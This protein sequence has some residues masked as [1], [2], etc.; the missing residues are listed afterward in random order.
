MARAKCSTGL[1]VTRPI[2]NSPALFPHRLLKIPPVSAV[3]PGKRSFRRGDHLT[4]CVAYEGIA[5][6]GVRFDEL[7]QHSFQCCDVKILRFRPGH[8]TSQSAHQIIGH[9]FLNAGRLIQD[10]EQPVAPMIRGILAQD[11]VQ[12]GDDA[13]E[14][15]HAEQVDADDLRPDTVPKRDTIHLGNYF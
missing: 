8:E 4:A 11:H 15:Q 14:R 13:D 10:A 1:P 6:G 9:G 5:D 7:L 12:G 3:E 2:S